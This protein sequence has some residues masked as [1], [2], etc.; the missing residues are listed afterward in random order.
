MKTYIVQIPI[1]M[2]VVGSVAADNEKHAIEKAM[3]I[4]DMEIKAKSELGFT[5]EE[6]EIHQYV[7]KGNV[8]YA[9]CSEADA[10]LEYD[11][12]EE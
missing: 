2:R 9:V 8:S 12:E 5:I 3:E 4:F 11:D 1:T 7:T 6:W 10:E